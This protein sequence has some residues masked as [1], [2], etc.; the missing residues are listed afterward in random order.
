MNR[1][2]EMRRLLSD[3]RCTNKWDEGVIAYANELLDKYEEQLDD[4]DFR[5]ATTTKEFHAAL[6]GGASSWAAFS[7]GACALVGDW[8]IAERLCDEADYMRLYECG[9]LERQGVTW[10]DEQAR[11]LAQ[12]ERI[13]IGVFIDTKGVKRN[14]S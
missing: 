5:E 13:L 9:G 10:A 2:E 11:A 4:G 14:D 12:A 6:L 8:E 1:V 3:K 7:Y